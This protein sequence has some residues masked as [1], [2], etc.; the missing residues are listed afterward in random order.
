MTGITDCL[1]M[2]L[3]YMNKD[4]KTTKVCLGVVDTPLTTEFSTIAAPKYVN[5]HCYW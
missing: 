1:E 2:E 4:I 3:A 5:I